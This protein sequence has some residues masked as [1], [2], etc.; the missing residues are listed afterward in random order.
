MKRITT[1]S[2]SAFS[3]QRDYRTV[4]A[5]LGVSDDT[6]QKRVTRALEK[7]RDL[8]SQRGIR[9][10][11]AALSVANAA[12][13]VQAAPAGL[14]T[15]ISTAALA[16]TAVTTS[17][18]IAAATKT[19]AMTTLQKILIAAT[20]TILAG[21]GIYQA[22]QA[23]QL[24]AE[25]VTLRQQQQQQAALAGQ[26][27]Q[28]QHQRDDATNQLANLAAEL[29]AAKRNPSEVLK[30]RGEVGSLRQENKQAGE[31]SALSKLTAD[32]A[33][34]KAMRDTQKIGMT[35]VYKDFAKQL[36]LSPEMTGK[37]N[38]LLADNVMDNVDLI[39]QALARR[40]IAGGSRPDFLR[41]QHRLS[42][43]DP[44]AAR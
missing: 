38:D 3:R 5:A 20:V 12:N 33:T 21:A 8:L 35:G 27:Q 24:R 15:T 40:Q 16:G 39:T 37:L 2:S 11:A 25:N 30:L 6:A 18:V 41:R 10:T 36:N 42:K 26:M 44:G 29:A 19:I 32:P 7:L 22:R 28:L 34:R 23:A 17:T 31:K 9:A 4:G 14:A 1:P 43:Q 13:A